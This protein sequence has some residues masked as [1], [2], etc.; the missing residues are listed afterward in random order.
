MASW[1]WSGGMVCGVVCIICG[2][3]CDRV[4]C[5]VRVMCDVMEWSGV[6]PCVVQWSVWCHR[7]VYDVMVMEWCH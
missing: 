2:M 7:V 3:L 5:G 6:S 4:M 1:S